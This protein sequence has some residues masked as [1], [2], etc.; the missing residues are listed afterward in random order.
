MRYDGQH[1][2]RHDIILDIEHEIADVVGSMI[3][4]RVFFLLSE[5]LTEDSGVCSF[6]NLFSYTRCL[7]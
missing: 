6:S 2:K 5:R 1:M 4:N 7:Q 3:V